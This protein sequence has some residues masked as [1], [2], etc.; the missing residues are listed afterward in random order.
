LAD[1]ILFD[2]IYHLFLQSRHLHSS[3]H[4]KPLFLHPHLRVLH[5]VFLQLHPPGQF[6]GEGVDAVVVVELEAAILVYVLF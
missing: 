4:S 1:L 5:A 2:W 3:K 6:E